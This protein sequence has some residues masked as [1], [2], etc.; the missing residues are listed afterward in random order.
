MVEVA[1]ATSA[2]LVSALGTSAKLAAVAKWTKFKQ[3]DLK[4]VAEALGLV[5]ADLEDELPGLV[6]CLTDEQFEELVGKWKIEGVVPSAVMV[7]RFRFFRSNCK[8]LFEAGQAAVRAV[9]LGP[10]E[11]VVK[12]P[13]VAPSAPAGRK[14]KTSLVLDPCDEAEVKVA[15]PDRIAQWYLNHQRAKGGP[16]MEESEPTPEQ[17]SAMHQRVVTFNLEPY[18][19]F[20]LLTPYG[21]RIAKELRHRS[22]LPQ[23]DGSYKPAMAKGPDDFSTWQACYKVYAAAL[24]M[25]CFDDAGNK[26]VVTPAALEVYYERFR[27]LVDDHPEVWFLCVKAEDRARAELFPRLRRECQHSADTSWDTVFLKAAENDKYWDREVRRPALRF[28]ARGGGRDLASMPLS[29]RVEAPHRAAIEGGSAAA[30]GGSGVVTAAASRRARRKQAVTKAAAAPAQRAGG[31]RDH[32]G[33]YLSTPDGKSIC[34]AFHG[35]GCQDPCKQGRAH[36]CQGRQAR[37]EATELAVIEPLHSNGKCDGPDT[38]CESTPGFEPHSCQVSSKGEPLRLDD[39]TEDLSVGGLRDAARSV[40]KLPILKDAGRRLRAAWE[41]WL[42]DDLCAASEL[43][44]VA[45]KL[46]T[47]SA[48]GFSNKTVKRARQILLNVAGW[49]AEA[50][51]NFTAGGYCVEA[52]EAWAQLSCEP[53]VE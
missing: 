47:A 39:E 28:L 45:A 29:E 48:S 38:H 34:F 35:R 40:D 51:L 15:E 50:E 1:A 11:A 12:L 26:P 30:S 32:K 31:K 8:L 22:W 21:R 43:D 5:E 53:D 2:D 44:A 18:A 25:I 27:Q 46:G 10:P 20:S 4:F 23:E 3:G 13:D 49:S 36:V 7:S 52:M 41:A 24:L 19:D 42:V 37:R 6:A 17:I 16:P 9:L 33:R 14:V